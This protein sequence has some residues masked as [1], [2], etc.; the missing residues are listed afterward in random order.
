MHGDSLKSINLSKKPSL[1]HRNLRTVL[2]PINWKFSAKEQSLRNWDLWGPLVFI[3]LLSFTL[4]WGSPQ[5]S[6]VFAMVFA[7]TAV[8]AVIMTWTVTLLGGDIVF[9]QALCLLGYCLFPICVAALACS[10]ISIGV[11]RYPFTMKTPPLTLLTLLQWV[12]LIVIVGG[13]TWASAATIPFIGNA[14]PVGRKFLAIYPVI[15][16]YLSLGWLSF[17]KS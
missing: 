14:V 3:L 8:G 12:R 1:A 11:R 15:L 5:A 17:V 13:I 7:E 16:L 9:F 6:T 4:S 10:A 2:I